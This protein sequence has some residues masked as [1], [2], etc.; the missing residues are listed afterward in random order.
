M[1]WMDGLKGDWIPHVC[2]VDNPSSNPE[3]PIPKNKGHEAMVYLS[4]IIDHY[5]NLPERTV[6]V[7][8]H[9]KS[10]HQHDDIIPLLKGLKFDALE[11]EGYVSLRCDWYPSCPAEIKPIQKNAL[12][13]GPGVH[14]QD[15]EEGII[16]VWP[17]FFPNEPIPETIAS[18]CCAQFVVT[19]PTIRKRKKDEY[20]RMRQWLLDTPLIDDIS[21]RVL[22]K[23]WAYIMTRDAVHCPQPNECS[24]KY[25]GRCEKREWP[26]PPQGIQPRPTG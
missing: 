1:S 13:W 16:E 6:F 10:W 17:K 23:L 4:F 20:M 11:K 22:E 2:D 15:A 8:G 5:D 19:K 25:F 18:Q 7:H 14:R 3:F 21:G 9:E 24:C 12:V 26:Q